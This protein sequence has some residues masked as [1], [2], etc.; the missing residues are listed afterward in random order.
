MNRYS[1]PNAFLNLN[2]DIAA[3]AILEVI[4]VCLVMDQRESEYKDPDTHALRRDAARVHPSKPSS[5]AI[6]LSSLF[7]VCIFTKSKDQKKNEARDS[8]L[9]HLE[10]KQNMN[11]IEFS[12]DIV[13][14]IQLQN[15]YSQSQIVKVSFFVHSRLII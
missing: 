5:N 2:R 10:Q 8:F 15:H 12:N 13:H 7:S 9:D 11:Q 1:F 4:L 6:G 3:M 14:K